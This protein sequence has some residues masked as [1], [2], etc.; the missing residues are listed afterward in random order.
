MFPA[1]G[2]RRL[3][4]AMTPSLPS[5]R[6]SAAA[7]EGGLGSA[8][9]S[10]VNSS[11]STGRSSAAISW[12]FHAMISVSL[13]DIRPTEHTEHTEDKAENI[14]V[15]SVYSVGSLVP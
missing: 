15:Y 8:A 9:F 12:R 14:S 10:A 11:S 13:S 3:I 6:R 1:E 7:K 4:S 5:G 2:E